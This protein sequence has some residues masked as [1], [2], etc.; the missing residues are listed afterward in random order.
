MI[1]FK[2]PLISS[3]QKNA[4]EKKKIYGEDRNIVINP[5]GLG[6]CLCAHP[7]PMACDYTTISPTLPKTG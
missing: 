4:Y 5:E 7:L 3:K 1:F 6:Q 2:K